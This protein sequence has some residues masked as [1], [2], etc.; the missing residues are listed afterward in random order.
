MPDTVAVTKQPVEIPIA[1][2]LAHGRIILSVD[3]KDPLVTIVDDS[4]ATHVVSEVWP[5]C[6]LALFVGDKIFAVSKSDSKLTISQ[7]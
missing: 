4:K 2:E 7:G 5:G 6:T 1:K 3:M